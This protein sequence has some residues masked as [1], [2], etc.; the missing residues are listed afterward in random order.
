[1]LRLLKF[2]SLIGCVFAL[3]G[4]A[5]AAV[6]SPT[7]NVDVV[8]YYPADID[9][10]S[11]LVA[12]SGR[13]WTHNDSGGDAVLF[14]LDKATFNVDHEV[15]LPGAMATDWET[16]TASET[17]LFIGDCGNNRGARRDLAIY[18][19]AVNDL[20]KPIAPVE[21]IDFSFSGQQDYSKRKSHD[22]DCE[23]ITAVNDQL[24]LFTK[25]RKSLTTDLYILSQRGT[26]Q[27]AVKQRS[28]PVDGLITGADYNAQTG[29][30]ALL[31]Y[32][33][34]SVW[35]FSF[36]WLVPTNSASEILWEKAVRL[37]VQ[38]YGQW[39][40]IA[41]ESPDTL[42]LTAERSALGPNQVGRIKVTTLP[43]ISI[44]H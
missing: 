8:A 6:V 28:F 17:H 38:P 11:G 44:K 37:I 40:G 30:L 13:Y 35:G 1:M 27:R 32:T 21:K 42:L 4:C 16:V 33:K 29:V 31:G 24:W 36:I 43:E 5:Q 15:K 23:A 2:L 7:V 9:E 18:K 3:Q 34:A 26:P 14:G 22:Y 39:E 41:W 20:E 10:S 12:V 19:V 25:N